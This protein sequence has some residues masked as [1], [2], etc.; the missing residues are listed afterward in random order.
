MAIG[1]VVL[2]VIWGPIGRGALYLGRVPDAAAADS[3][4]ASSPLPLHSTFDRL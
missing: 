1:D 4:I 2:T 3:A